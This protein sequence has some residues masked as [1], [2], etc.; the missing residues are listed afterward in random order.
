MPL[1]VS[2]EPDAHLSNRKL[3]SSRRG[4]LALYQGGFANLVSPS[5]KG[6]YPLWR[7]AVRRYFRLSNRHSI[8][9]NW[10]LLAQCA[11]RVFA[12]FGAWPRKPSRRGGMTV[13]DSTP[14]PPFSPGQTNCVTEKTH[15]CCRRPPAV[16]E[17]DEQGCP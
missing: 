9:S 6:R 7:A 14:I 8:A 17:C 3:T 4:S 2:P 5:A 13:R 11:L 1:L 16:L 15:A 10:S 12:G